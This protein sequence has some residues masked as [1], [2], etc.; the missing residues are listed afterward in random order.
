MP[1]YPHDIF[2]VARATNGGATVTF[3]KGDS[4]MIAKKGTRFDFHESGNLFYLPTVEKNVDKCNVCHDMQTWHE[5]LGRCNYEDVQKLLGVVKGM[6]IRGSTVRPAELCEVCTKGKFTQTRNREADRKATEPLQLVH[7]DLAGPMRTSSLEGH[8]YAMSF[9]DSVQATERFLADSAPYGKVR[10][11]R[12]DN[13]TEY[14]NREFKALL[15]RNG[16]KHETSAPYSPHQ[17]GTAGR[18]WRT[19]YEMGRCILLDS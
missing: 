13:G 18:D 6:E 17:N 19:L 4:H 15:T 8:K 14:I 16:I 9:T 11:I 2:S 1:T 10:C 3:K 12:S 7:T 5:I